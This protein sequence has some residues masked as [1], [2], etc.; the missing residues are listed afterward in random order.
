M[1]TNLDEKSQNFVCACVY[2]IR[3]Y[4]FYKV[5]LNNYPF[6]LY[7][8]LCMCMWVP[9][10]VFICFTKTNWTITRYFFVYVCLCMFMCVPLCVD[11]CKR[12]MCA[13]ACCGSGRCGRWPSAEIT[14]LFLNCLCER[15]PD[16]S[17]LNLI[18]WRG[19]SDPFIFCFLIYAMMSLL[20]LFLVLSLFSL[21]LRC[22]AIITILTLVSLKIHVW[23]YMN[24]CVN[25]CVWECM[26]V[27]HSKFECVC[28]YI[29]VSERVRNI[30]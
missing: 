7:V 4:L 28:V 15:V 26:C 10:C 21:S 12:R 27:S 30:C 29:H 19:R 18:P 24:M 1:Y 3:I 16:G 9:L 20:L 14:K 5:K 23:H 25:R 11:S 6:F 22:S 17:H 2:Y 8:C 13:W